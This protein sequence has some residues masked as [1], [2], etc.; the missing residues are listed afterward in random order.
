MFDGRQPQRRTEGNPARVTDRG[1]WYKTDD[2]GA[3]FSVTTYSAESWIVTDNL[4]LNDRTAEPNADGTIT[5]RYNCPGMANNLDVVPD[6]TQ[7][8][9]PDQPE[10]ADA[11]GRYVETITRTVSIKPAS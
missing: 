7:V 1:R 6:W 4:A 11:I 9:G 2:A 8:M 3:F 5:F 10:S